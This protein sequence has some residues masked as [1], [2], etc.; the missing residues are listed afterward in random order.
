MKEY[1]TKTKNSWCRYFVCQIEEWPWRVNRKPFCNKTCPVKGVLYQNVPHKSFVLLFQMVK[2]QKLSI[3]KVWCIS[4][5][6]YHWVWAMRPYKLQ[7]CNNNVGMLQLAHPEPIFTISQGRINVCQSHNYGEI[8]HTNFILGPLTLIALAL[9]ESWDQQQC[10][11][12]TVNPTS[13]CPNSRNV[14][15]YGPRSKVAGGEHLDD[16]K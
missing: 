1:K 10:R 13:K 9:Q 7:H 16:M 8:I 12:R 5:S 11:A 14:Q 2:E 3:S 15:L 4:T 6:W